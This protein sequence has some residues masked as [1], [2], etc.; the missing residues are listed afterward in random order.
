MP[1]CKVVR[2]HVKTGTHHSAFNVATIPYLVNAYYH[3]V[4]IST[5]EQIGTGCFHLIFDVDGFPAQVVFEHVH[6][7]VGVIAAHF[8]EELFLQELA[9]V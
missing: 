4:A 1:N 2:C 5:P 6:T 3:T 9:N 8:L 7:F